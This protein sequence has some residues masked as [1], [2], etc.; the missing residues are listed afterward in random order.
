MTGLDDWS[1]AKDWAPEQIAYASAAELAAGRLP[2]RAQ[3]RLAEQRQ[4]AE[5]GDP[6]AFT[7]DLTVEE[8]AAIRSVGFAP[9]GQVLGTAVYQFAA[10]YQGCGFIGASPAGAPVVGLQ[11]AQASLDEARHLAVRRMRFECDALGGDGV[12]G[13]R[14]GVLPFHDIGLEFLAIGTAVRAA[15]AVRPLRPFTCD[16]SGQDFAKLIRAGWVPVALLQGVGVT[17][18]HNDW[19]Q[20]IQSLSWANQELVGATALVR[21]ARSVA[22][23]GLAQDAARVGAHTVVLRDLMSRMYERKCLS[24]YE[25][26][27]RIAEVV[28]WGTGIVPFGRKHRPHGAA[29]EPPLPMLRLNPRKETG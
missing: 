13:V 14:L 17:V 1:Y 8:F 11:L 22:R 26:H 19:S 20:R 27:D 24:G 12:V 16:L 7:S 9:V 5:R 28:L 4:R 6:G 21:G 2:L 18:R 25:A 3:W 10:V 29:T 15:G 23:T